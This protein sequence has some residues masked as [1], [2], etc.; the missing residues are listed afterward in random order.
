VVEA[1]R[2]GFRAAGLLFPVTLYGF[3]DNGFHVTIAL[4]TLL[5][6]VGLTVDYRRSQS[7]ASTGTESPPSR[8]GADARAPA[9]VSIP[10][11]TLLSFWIVVLLFPGEVAIPA[12][13]FAAIGAPVAEIVGTRR[14]RP[15]RPGDRLLGALVGF[16][17]CLG[18]AGLLLLLPG[19]GFD[20][21][22][23]SIG[24]VAAMIMILVPA[25]V[26]GAFSVP[27]FGAAV[28]KL[29]RVLLP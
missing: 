24:A 7:A 19:P 4:L 5:L 1:K 9:W 10:T 6:A 26:D 23:L 14:G 12:M 3:G 16:L 21:R 2:T 13:V 22:T 15:A 25:P 17:A 20:F 18:A 8:A 27:L 11:L 28:M 29:T